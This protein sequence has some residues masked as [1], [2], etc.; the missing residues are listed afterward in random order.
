MSR[1]PWLPKIQQLFWILFLVSLPVTSF[2]YFPSGLGGSTLVRPLALYPLLVLL[3]IAVLPRL[4]Q[5]PAPRTLLP[6]LAFVV[7]AL[8]S[9]AFSL[10]RDIDPVL[11]VSV[12]DRAIRT[13]ISLFLGGAFYLAV[14]LIPQNRDD[15]RF[16]LRWLYA[17]FAMALAW[18]SLQALYVVHFNSV[19]FNI[20]KQLQSLVSIRKLFPTRISGMT[21]EPNWFAEQISFLLMPWLFTAVF[22]GY[23]A[24]RWRWRKLTVEMLLLVWATGVLLFTYSRAGL[25]LLAVQLSLIF[26]IRPRRSTDVPGLKIVGQRLLQAGLALVVLAGI[27][28]IAGSQNNYFSRL[29][30]YWSDE[31]STGNYLQ[32]IAFDQRFAYWGT[33]YQIYADHPILGVGLGNYT[34][35]FDEYLSDQPLYPTPELLALLTPEAGRSQITSVKSFF[36][37]LLAETGLL[38]TATFLAFLLA[39]LGSTLYLILSP[40]SEDQFWGRAGILVLVV[41]SAISFSFDSFSLPNMWIVLGFITAAAHTS[42]T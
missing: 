28:F 21:Y 18:G 16:S 25:I 10:L 7:V 5:R 4:W 3:V 24:F 35:Y 19:Y 14:T 20:F 15:L 37:R 22:S 29:W 41:F 12:P 34:F 42:K 27:V 38:G 2:P 36:P 13:L 11:G 1:F 32:Y 26:L 17:G 9:T 39:I 40:E 8:G 31:E 30:N 23:S 6:F 33:A